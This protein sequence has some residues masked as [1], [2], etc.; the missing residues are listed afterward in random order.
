MTHTNLPVHVPKRP[1]QRIDRE[2]LA[3]DIREALR[4]PGGTAAMRSALGRSLQLITEFA[5]AEETTAM[6]RDLARTIDKVR[7]LKDIRLGHVGRTI[8]IDITT[9]PKGIR[10]ITTVVVDI[11][12]V[13]ADDATVMFIDKKNLATGEW[14]PEYA[15]T[16]PCR[17]LPVDTL[18][19][20]KTEHQTTKEA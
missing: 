6:Y 4:G 10:T 13:D 20:N 5:A 2:K 14:S 15:N 8:E 11:G 16:L 12:A 17:L 7:T 3:N 19:A 1:P 9:Y 18:P